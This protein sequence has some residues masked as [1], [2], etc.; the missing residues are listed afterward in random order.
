MD[1]VLEPLQEC[2]GAIVGDIGV[3]TAIEIIEFIAD[4]N[5]IIDA[6]GSCGCACAGH[7][8][9]GT[10]CSP[11]LFQEYTTGLKSKYTLEYF[12]AKKNT[13]PVNRCLNGCGLSIQK[14][15]PK[16]KILVNS[17][18]YKYIF[19]HQIDFDGDGDGD[20]DD[21]EEEEEEEG[22]GEEKATESLTAL[23]TA[24]R[25]TNK[26]VKQYEVVYQSS[27]FSGV[28]DRPTRCTSKFIRSLQIGDVVDVLDSKGPWV[29]IG[30][31]E[32]ILARS[33][34]TQ[35]PP[36]GVWKFLSVMAGEEYL[37]DD[38]YLGERFL[39]TPIAAENLREKERLSKLKYYVISASGINVRDKPDS[40]GNVVRA[41]KYLDIVHKVPSLPN[42]DPWLQIGINEWVLS[43]TT[44]GLTLLLSN[45]LP[46]EDVKE[47][48]MKTGLVPCLKECCQ[49][50]LFFC[51]MFAIAAITPVV[52]G[53][54]TAKKVYEASRF[55]HDCHRTRM[56]TTHLGEMKY[57][58][59]NSLRKKMNKQSKKITIPYSMTMKCCLL[60]SRGCA[61]AIKCDT[62]S[63]CL[64]PD[65]E[66]DLFEAN[67]YRRGPCFIKEDCVSGCEP[68]IHPQLGSG[69][70]RNGIPK[71]DYCHTGNCAHRNEKPVNHWTLEKDQE[72]RRQERQNKRNLNRFMKGLSPLPPLPSFVYQPPPK[73]LDMT[74]N[75]TVDQKIVPITVHDDIRNWSIGTADESPKDT[76]ISATKV[77][78][79]EKKAESAPLFL[80]TPTPTLAPTTSIPVEIEE[81]SQKKKL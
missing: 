57:G 81:A 59:F 42:A 7:C 36:T 33:G 12:A 25:A 2:A 70:H 3:A 46:I 27:E 44:P 77:V 5:K 56:I 20:D 75:I 23:T 60:T 31:N 54:K 61:L 14:N 64:S 67:F 47:I 51:R 11:C 21:E 41:L 30:N 53:M 78:P 39:M 6:F 79:V 15:S 45:D 29:K 58:F 63:E 28:R 1:C 16:I 26:N 55:T 40:S 8:V 69:F 80:E 43:R 62:D 76:N 34:T 72:F 19:K 65:E 74:R 50:P 73:A 10:L 37:G 48:P 35:K 71:T 49:V 68:D 9:Y 24:A 17:A 13:G 22:E 38:W 52:L 66:L 18:R 4:H 32:W